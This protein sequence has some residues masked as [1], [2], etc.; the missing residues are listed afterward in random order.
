M[1]LLRV[2]RSL[3][4]E[5]Q[6][7]IVAALTSLKTVAMTGVYFIIASAG[8]NGVGD[9]TSFLRWLSGHWIWFSL[10]YIAGA[11]QTAASSRNTPANPVIVAQLKNGGS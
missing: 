2:W 4:V 5:E 7:K 9:D 1:N 6:A 3:T 8:A 10:A 11:T